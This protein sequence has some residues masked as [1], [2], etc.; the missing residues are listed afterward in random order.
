MNESIMR[1]FEAKTRPGVWCQEA[2]VY[3]DRSRI[4]VFVVEIC[5][6]MAVGE[7]RRFTSGKCEVNLCWEL[8]VARMTMLLAAIVLPGDGR[9]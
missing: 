9:C 3:R 7:E 2:A 8:V 1:T 6:G 5:Q 4:I